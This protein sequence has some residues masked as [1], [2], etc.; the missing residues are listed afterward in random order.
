MEIYNKE[1]KNLYNYHKIF[2]NKLKKRFMINLNK[3][4]RFLRKAKTI[5]FPK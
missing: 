4:R 2:L 5:K 3:L 1:Y